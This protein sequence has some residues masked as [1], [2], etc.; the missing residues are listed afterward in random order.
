MDISEMNLSE[1]EARSAEICAEVENA[2]EEKLAELKAEA[3][4][5]AERK[6][7]L[8]AFEQRK[9]TAGK[10]NSGEIKAD[11]IERSEPVKEEKK[12]I[13]RKSTE[14]RDA[15]LAM[16][17]GTETAEQRAIVADGTNFGDG[18]ALPVEVEENVW[19][20]VC[21]AHPIMADIDVVRS[22]I[23]LKVPQITPTVISAK[24]D[25]AASSEM[26]YTTAE[27]VLAGKDYHSYIS[28]TYAEAKMA[29][30]ALQSRIENV[31]AEVIGEAMAKDVFAR[32][33]SDAGSAAITKSTS[34]TWL[35]CLTKALGAAS[36]ANAPIV[37]APASIYYE[38]V[39]ATDTVG[40]PVFR[41]GLVLNAQFKLDNA[42]T[43]VTIVEPKKFILNM[44]Q[45]I[46]IE[47]GRDVKAAHI[48]IGGYARA[49]GCLRVK[50]AA[51]YI[52]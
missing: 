6:A 5:L 2:T 14:Y 36:L 21:S 23:V 12:M 31:L 4:K 19:N 52:G 16:M 1:V 32:I 40:Q 29:M 17:V 42:A 3:E 13:D 20:Q 33:L 35:E 25:S 37:Y 11:V 34:N 24:K 41:N 30:S 51:A 28:L 46:M 18:I 38:V 7:E 44:V 43:K 8:Q 47:S 48:D 39:G 50:K 49:E 45:D 9:D 27:V 26:T 15:F 22:G 10:I